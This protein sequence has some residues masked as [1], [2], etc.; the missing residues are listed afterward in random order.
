MCYVFTQVW[1]PP[2]TL[3][4][5][6][7]NGDIAPCWQPFSP[8]PHT[9]TRPD[10]RGSTI[11]ALP[12]LPTRVLQYYTS[13]PDQTSRAPQLWTTTGGRPGLH[14]WTT[15]PLHQGVYIIIPSYFHKARP[16][17]LHK[18]GPPHHQSSLQYH[19]RWYFILPWYFYRE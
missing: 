4:D 18:I 9:S 19:P 2:S 5:L 14:Q 13:I 7:P 8:L 17:G 11:M 15:I 12:Y 3:S 1:A 6:F 10:L 16:Q